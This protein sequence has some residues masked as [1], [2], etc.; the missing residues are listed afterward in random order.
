MTCKQF[1]PCSCG[2]L[3]RSQAAPWSLCR[4]QRLSSSFCA[5]KDSQAKAKAALKAVKKGAMK[6]E[7]K[8]R[9]SVIFHRPK[10]LKRS[11]DPKYSRTRYYS[12]PAAACP[13]RNIVMKLTV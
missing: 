9:K 4:G 5:G 2:S 6:K 1:F 11:R 12:I 13:K 7:R 8:V 3:S 10:T